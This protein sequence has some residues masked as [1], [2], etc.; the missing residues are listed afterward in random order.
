M[1]NPNRSPATWALTAAACSSLAIG[2]LLFVQ[3]VTGQQSDS[4]LAGRFGD[5][6]EEIFAA[7]CAAC[8]AP[9]GRGRSESQLGFDLPLPNFTDC[10][11]A[12]REP[13]A[14][15]FAIAARAAD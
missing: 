5:T 14:D 11:F 12:S 1:I 3:K 9:D 13:S 15:W 10:N 8:H 2:S 4:G 7:A 6:P